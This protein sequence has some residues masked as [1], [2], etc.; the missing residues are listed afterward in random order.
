MKFSFW[1]RRIAMLALAATFVFGAAGKASADPYT[2]K[3]SI[4]NLS[5]WPL[6]LALSPIVAGKTVYNN[7]NSIGDSP[8]VRI[9]YPLPGFLW[10]TFVQGAASV[11]RGVTGVIEFVP[12]VAL[13]FTDAEIDPIFDPVEDQDALVDYETDFFWLKFGVTYTSG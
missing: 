4:E 1:T 8:G 5:Q 12:G 2:L 10:N 7:L 13:F 9:A 3:R 6:D 11:L